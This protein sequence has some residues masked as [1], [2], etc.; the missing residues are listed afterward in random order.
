MITFNDFK[1]SFSGLYPLVAN[2]SD[3][4]NSY[5]ADF[6]GYK[7]GRLDGIQIIAECGVFE[8]SEG[9]AGQDQN[10]LHVFKNYKNV[11]NAINFIVKLNNGAKKPRPIKVWA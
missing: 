7:N 2:C 1:A 5:H 4:G 9:Q 10:E 3:L 11:G 8:V 6:S